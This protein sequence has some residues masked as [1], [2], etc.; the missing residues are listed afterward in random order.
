MWINELGDMLD[1]GS[2][3]LTQGN[4]A[5][6]ALIRF[7]EHEKAQLGD[8]AFGGTQRQKTFLWSRC[9]DLSQIFRREVSL[10][11]RIGRSLN[12]RQRTPFSST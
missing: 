1:N 3:N 11:A 7:E 5:P 6:Q 8:T 12:C 9:I 4:E 2:R 10:E